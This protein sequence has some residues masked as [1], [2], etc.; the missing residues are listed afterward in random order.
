MSTINYSVSLSRLERFLVDNVEDY[1]ALR[2]WE[3]IEVQPTQDSATGRPVCN[4]TFSPSRTTH[5]V[6]L[7]DLELGL[8]KS[9]IRLTY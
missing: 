2:N 6:P 1:S 8:R 9:R 3:Q 5:P 4:V 7:E